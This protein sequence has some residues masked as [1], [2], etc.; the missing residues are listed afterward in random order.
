MFA[1]LSIALIGSVVGYC[2][3]IPMGE[4]FGAVIAILLASRY[5]KFSLSLPKHT[6]IFIQ[7]VLGMSV[8][9]VVSF[10]VITDQF[11]PILLIALICCLAIQTMS[12]FLWLKKREGWSDVDSF[13]GAIPGA[14]AAILSMGDKYASASPKVIFAHSVR[15]II[16]VSTAATISYF[17]PSNVETTSSSPQWFVGISP[18]LLMVAAISLISGWLASKIGVPAPYM[19]MALICSVVVKESIH[20]VT[21]VIP[22]ALLWLS[23]MALGAFIGLR[24]S[25]VSVD[26]VVSYVRAGVL[27]TAIS[28]SV[29]ILFSFVMSLITGVEWL[30]L[31]LSWVPGNVEAMT[32]V[33]LMLGLEPAFVMINHVVRLGILHALPLFFRQFLLQQKQ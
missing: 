15:L 26:H 32:A 9:T 16:L 5:S 12:A 19:V 18:T 11:S 28:L 10:G 13:L 30:V 33:A 29:T 1:A 21:L 17:T 25:E 27:V 31:L 4:L 8:G 20:E 2:L 23:T 14:L 24:L 7:T 22:A 6:I 3:S